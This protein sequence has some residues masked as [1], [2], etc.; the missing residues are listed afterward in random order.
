MKLILMC[1]VTIDGKIAK[2]PG[3]FVNWTGSEDKKIFSRETKRA[4]VVIM[5]NSTFKTIGKPLKS[6]LNIVLTLRHAGEQGQKGILEYTAEPPK[7][8]LRGLKNRGF[9]K[10]FLIGGGRVN[11][12]FIK[13]NLVNEVWLTVV[14]RIFGRGINLFSDFDGN[15]SLEFVSC[16]RLSSG[17]LFVKYQ[18]LNGK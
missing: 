18:V 4:G 16:E 15:V 11:S 9:K 5:G 1:A 14:P 17:L 10:A 8:I 12:L 6:R 2:K 7:E 3:E 13:N